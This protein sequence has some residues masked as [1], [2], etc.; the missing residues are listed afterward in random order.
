M[1]KKTNLQELNRISAEIYDIS[2]N[3]RICI[4]LDNLRSA[5]NIG[6][7]FRTA[8]AFHI[9]RIYLCGI[10][11]IPPNKEINKTAL[12]ATNSVKWKYFKDTCEAI[13]SVKQSKYEVVAIEQTNKSEELQDFKFH[14]D[15]KYA[16]I[17]G[18]EVN[19]ITEKILSKIDSFVEIPQFGT[20][21]SFNVSI[22]AGIVLWDWHNKLMIN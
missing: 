22:S 7:I 14:S 6:S 13:R 17:F 4:I 10:T 20:K 8:D 15:K 21:H 5:H 9:K 1:T 19:G 18:N 3:D 11:A 12:G 2:A 16:L